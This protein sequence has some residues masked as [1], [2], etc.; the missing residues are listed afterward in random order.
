MASS[1]VPFVSEAERRKWGYLK[2]Q[3]HITQDQ[4]DARQQ[5]TGSG[6]LP[7]RAKPRKHS[8]GASRSTDAAKIGKTRY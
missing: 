6:N 7:E 5:A 2:D 8:V 3:G 4:Y 1:S